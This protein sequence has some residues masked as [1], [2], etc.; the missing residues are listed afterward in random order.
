MG[1]VVLF[2]LGIGAVLVGVN[3]LAVPQNKLISPANQK[4]D[5]SVLQ[6]IIDK[7]VFDENRDKIKG[8]AF[9]WALGDGK[10]HPVVDGTSYVVVN[11]SGK[12]VFGRDADEKRSPASLTKLVSAMVLLD[13][14]DGTESFEVQKESVNLEP[15]ILMVDE[16]EKLSVDELLKAM[17]MTS[18][19]DAADVAARSLS[20]KL[21]GSVEVFVMLMNEKVKRLGLTNTHFGNATGY[22]DD[23]QY[24]TARELAKIAYYA[25]TKYPK[26]AKI[27]KTQEAEIEETKEHKHYALPNWNALLSVYPGVDGI[28]IGHTERAGY[29]TIVTSARGDEKMLAVLLGAPDRRARDMWTAQLLNSAFGEVGIHP[30][31]VTLAMLQKREKDWTEQLQKAQE[32]K[33]R[34]GWIYKT[35]LEE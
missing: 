28:K 29:V 27:V 4:E 22:D 34:F 10:E 25:T 21:G 5:Q 35:T 14:T 1:K 9:E 20:K 32:F 7:K 23:S 11:K 3:F 13:L 8:E 2:L 17:L 6:K 12:V 24:S 16:G 26:I 18:A 19:N 15:T 31:R 33:S 30:F